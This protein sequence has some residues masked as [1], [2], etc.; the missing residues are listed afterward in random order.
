M[1]VWEGEDFIDRVLVK[2]DDVELLFE[3]IKDGS[4]CNLKEAYKLSYTCLGDED[5]EFVIKVFDPSQHLPS[6][7]FVDEIK[8]LFSKKMYLQAYNLLSTKNFDSHVIGAVF[9]SVKELAYIL[10]LTSEHFLNSGPVCG[11]T[12]WLSSKL[13]FCERVLSLISEVK[14]NSCP[15]L[16]SLSK[17]KEL[18]EKYDSEYLNSN[19]IIKL[20]IIA[21]CFLLMCNYERGLGRY[22]VSTLYLHRALETT[23]KSWLL[24]ERE[25]SLDADGEVRGD[26]FLYLLDYLDL[27]KKERVILDNE[28]EV[29][30]IFNKLRNKNKLAHGYTEVE[31]RILDGM[32][33]ELEKVIFSDENVKLYYSE[34]GSIIAGG[35]DL[36]FL[37]RNFLLDNAYLKKLAL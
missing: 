12:G 11:S 35:D 31:S 13:E 25:I 23:F 19:P 21:T 22:S 33:F 18:S 1:K 3:S 14:V 36:F 6:L 29:I 16:S 32:Y 4:I 15:I 30:K 8:N 2:P 10:N 28:S 17:N 27:V 34:I 37:I 5:V 20:K 24:E 9:S 7:D 26:K